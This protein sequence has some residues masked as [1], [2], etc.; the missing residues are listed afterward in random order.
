[1][2]QR[3]RGGVGEGGTEGRREGFKRESSFDMKFNLSLF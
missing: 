3:G 1:M 2:G